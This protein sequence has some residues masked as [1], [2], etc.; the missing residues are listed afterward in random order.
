M[1]RGLSY[2]YLLSLLFFFFVEGV[3]IVN[4]VVGAAVRVECMQVLGLCI[5]G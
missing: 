4:D 3:V 2:E 1:E 5:S